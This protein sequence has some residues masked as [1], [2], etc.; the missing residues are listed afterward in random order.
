MNSICNQPRQRGA[1]SRA[2]LI[3]GACLVGAQLVAQE[4]LNESFEVDRSRRA[5]KEA[6]DR[7]LYNLKAGPV[8]LRFD[9]LMGFE[10]NDN[11]QL[12]E[13]PDEVDFAF[14]PELDMAALWALNARNALSFNLGVGYVKYIHNTDLDHLVIAPTSEIALDIYTG[15]FVIN[16]HER[17]SHSQDPVRDPTVSGTGDFGGI[18]NTAGVRAD[19][20]L[21]KL[22]VSAGYD[23]YNFIST[24]SGIS[25]TLA[26]GTNG[27]PLGTNGPPINGNDVQDRSSELFY[28]RAGI[29]VF[30]A[31]TVGVEASGGLT[32]YQS[33]FFHDNWQFSAGSFVEAQISR[34][35][36]GRAAGG[37]IHSQFEPHRFAPAPS[38]VDDFYA[39]LS[40][41]Q[42]LNQKLSH[43]LSVGREARSGAAAEL[44]TLWYARYENHWT[45]NRF[46]TLH[47]TLFYEKGRERSGLTEKFERV[48]AGAG[49]TVPLSRK[50]NAGMGYQLL[51]KNSNQENRDYVQNSFIVDLR[52]A[53]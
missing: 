51:F 20:N 50:L 17:V 24:G 34:D 31:A 32:D 28:G 36:K 35:L 18:E 40:V 25:K 7:N 37:Y 1:T 53:F 29:Q 19:W 49:V 23:H 22:T 2:A 27:P 15:D 48:G 52:Y 46:S 11:P 13:H 6:I 5:R 47:T 44:V 3:S 38:P 9:A 42:Q 43:K 41:E 14:R 30:P 16:V 4:A 8:L 10:V 21:N 45:M 39:E 12:E 33:D 26:V